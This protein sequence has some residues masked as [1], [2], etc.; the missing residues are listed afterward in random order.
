MY[1][2]K[3]CVGD[4]LLIRINL[5]VKSLN[6]MHEFLDSILSIVSGHKKK[7]VRTYIVITPFMEYT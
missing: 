4:H 2:I 3:E 5:V 1:L 7:C 6:N